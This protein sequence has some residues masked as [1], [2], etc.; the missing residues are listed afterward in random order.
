[1]A[2]AA[3]ILVLGSGVLAATYIW[4]DE[5]LQKFSQR[6]QNKVSDG[7]SGTMDPMGRQKYWGPI[8][9]GMMVTGFIMKN[10]DLQKLGA[11]SL[12]SL[13]L[14][15]GFTTYLKNAT[16][17]HRPDRSHLNNKFDGSDPTSIH[18]SFPSAHTTV[19]FV[20]STSISE[21]Y[22]HKNRFVSPAAHTVA[23]LVGLS[24]INDNAHW[25]TDVMAGAALGYLSVKGTATV[26]DFLG[27]KLGEGKQRFLIMP[28]GTLSRGTVNSSLIF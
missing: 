3:G 24:R 7:I 19:A 10:P 6:Y 28:S 14:S 5:P 18:R 26:Y 15:G 9:G 2:K 21:V 22:G 13:F 16:H 17:R 4:V 11:V 8:S 12:G 20:M 23:T 27:R 1:M 25:A